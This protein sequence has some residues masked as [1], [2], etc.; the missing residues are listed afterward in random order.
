MLLDD[1]IDA[2]CLDGPNAD[3]LV[4]EN[5]ANLRR[6]EEALAKERYA[7]AVA[8]GNESL[9]ETID[10]FLEHREREGQPSD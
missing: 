7:I 3:Q 9:L 8:R 5:P 1:R 10:E 4:R 2:V 6:L